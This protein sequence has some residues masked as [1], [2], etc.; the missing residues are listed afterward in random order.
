LL[1]TLFLSNGSPSLAGLLALSIIVACYY[2]P[3]PISLLAS[4]T[5]QNSLYA[6][7]LTGFYRPETDRQASFSPAAGQKLAR[8]VGTA[9]S[10]PKLDGSEYRGV[11]PHF[12]GRT[13]PF[14][15][16]CVTSCPHSPCASSARLVLLLKNLS[17]QH[18]HHRQLDRCS[19]NLLH[20]DLRPPILVHRPSTITAIAHLR[21]SNFYFSCPPPKCPPPSNP[22]SSKRPWRPPA[23]LPLPRP[24]L[25]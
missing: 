8:M 4:A 17:L 1:R 18:R 15:C 16:P 11:P 25:S 19:D 23:P 2:R 24:R 10:T 7:Q 9:R 12:Q 13:R 22:L 6:R 3:G 5:E 14:Q 21:R 20:D